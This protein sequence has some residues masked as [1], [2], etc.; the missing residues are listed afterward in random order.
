MTMENGMQVTK[1]AFDK[2]NLMKQELLEEFQLKYTQL[3][4]LVSAM[5][6]HQGM[7][8]NGFARADEFF[9][10]IREAINHIQYVEPTPPAPTPAPETPPDA[11]A[12][13][14]ATE[15]VAESTPLE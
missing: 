15:K 3:V 14:E 7:R 6:L 10:W 2:H 12:P 8:M 4:R 1:A 13:E 11:P 9:F 5:P